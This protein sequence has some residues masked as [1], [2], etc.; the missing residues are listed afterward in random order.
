SDQF[1][2][3][4]RPVSS[5]TCLIH[6][7]KPVSSIFQTSLIHISNQAHP[8]SSISEFIDRSYTPLHEVF[9]VRPAPVTFQGKKII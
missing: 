4:F 7:F 1:H 6:S 8:Y 9:E 2:P 3:Y 5:I